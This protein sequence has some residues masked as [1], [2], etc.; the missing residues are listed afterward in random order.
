[1]LGDFQDCEVEAAELRSIAR[2][3]SMSRADERAF[4]GLIDGIERRGRSARKEFADV[5]S[6]F[7]TK[8][9]RRAMGRIATTKG[10]K[11]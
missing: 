8:K 6:E 5:F 9:V 10:P 1:M 4:G 7:D 11:R 2:D 3:V